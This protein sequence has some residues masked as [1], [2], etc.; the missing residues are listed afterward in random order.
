VKDETSPL[1]SGD[2]LPS[3][4]EAGASTHGS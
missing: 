1:T 3:P 2:E 4:A